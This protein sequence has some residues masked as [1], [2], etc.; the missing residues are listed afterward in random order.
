MKGIIQ[1]L[2]NSLSAQDLRGMIKAAISNKKIPVE[3]QKAIATDV[4]GNLPAL[5]QQAVATEV[6]SKQGD[7]TKRKILKDL[8]AIAVAGGVGYATGG[9]AGAISAGVD[10][11]IDNLKEQK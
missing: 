6:F 10:Q 2:I 5:D 7:D 4:I 1:W 3:Q 9:Q 11:L 8:L